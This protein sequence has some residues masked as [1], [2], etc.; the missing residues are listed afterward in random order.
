MLDWVIND[1][2][3]ARSVTSGYAPHTT[4]F[5]SYVKQNVAEEVNWHPTK[6]VDLG[7]ILGLEQY[8]RS[9]AQ[10]NRTTEWSAKFYDVVTPTDWAKFRSSYSFS[11]RRYSNYDWQTY[12]GN[13]IISPIVP[14]GTTT[15][16]VE[17]PGMRTYDMANRDR[18]IG[19]ASLDLDFVPGLTVTPTAGLRFDRYLTN[20]ADP[21]N[22]LGL[23]RDNNWNGGLEVTYAVT[24]RVT[25]FAS[26]MTEVYNRRMFDGGGVIAGN[27]SSHY[28]TDMTGLANTF[29]G[30]IDVVLIPKSLDLKLSGTLVRS[31]DQWNSGTAPGGSSGLV[32]NCPGT[33][34]T[35]VGL[36][37]AVTDTFKRFDA[38]LRYKVDDSVV[39]QLGWVGDVYL[40]VKYVYESNFV[41]NW[42]L[43][44]MQQYMYYAANARS[45]QIYM[46]GD[47]PNYTA[48]YV[49]G[50]VALKW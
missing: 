39:K 46:A 45:Q 47:N 40:K 41:D 4:I 30:A 1:S 48:Q 2:A 16:L 13:T 25:L 23:V 5:Q 11:G 19:K 18:Q 44:N 36:W 3:S 17:N 15:S 35:I 33:C 21:I 8:D 10:T 14:G 26:A 49:M 43:G 7:F 34:S 31:N 24:D 28:F 38:T 22:Q 6:A 20:P 27:P 37:P 9:Q 29:V 12:V 42:A 32:S 50:S